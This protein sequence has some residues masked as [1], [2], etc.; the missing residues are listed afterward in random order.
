MRQ[1]VLTWRV[2]IIMRV[3]V[4]GVPVI[5][6]MAKPLPRAFGVASFTFLE[7]FSSHGCQIRSDQF[8]A[9]KS[10]PVNR[11]SL[12]DLCC[13]K[14]MLR[15]QTIVKARAPR[16]YYGSVEQPIREQRR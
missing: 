4:K 13:D 14:R 2:G 8:K 10:W 1:I 15:E 11:F 9:K 5:P 7:T 12:R 6:N 3:R 16:H